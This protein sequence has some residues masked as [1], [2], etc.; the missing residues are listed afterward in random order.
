[1]LKKG[2]C[3]DQYLLDVAWTWAKSNDDMIGYT[4]NCLSQYLM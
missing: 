3:Y 1:M 2:Y 4:A